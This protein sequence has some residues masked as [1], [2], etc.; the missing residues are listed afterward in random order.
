MRAAAVP[1]VPHAPRASIWRRRVV[2]VPAGHRGDALGPSW[3]AIASPPCP[4]GTIA[5]VRVAFDARAARSRRATQVF[6]PKSTHLG[7]ARPTTT[8]SGAVSAVLL[9]NRAWRARIALAGSGIPAWHAG[10]P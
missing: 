8:A 3:S 9:P 1:F 5:T 4:H 10:V 7:V 2:R 6:R